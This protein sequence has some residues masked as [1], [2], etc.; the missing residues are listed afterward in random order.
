MFSITGFCSDLH[1]CFAEREGFEPPVPVRAQRFSRPPRSTTPASLLNWC[2]I[3]I[4]V[5]YLGIPKNFGAYASEYRFSAS[6]CGNM[7]HSPM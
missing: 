6:C 3:I 2:K 5:R 4:F 7:P 1:T